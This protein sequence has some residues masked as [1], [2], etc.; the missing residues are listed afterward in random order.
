MSVAIDADAPA[1]EK[2][3]FDAEFDTT[4]DADDELVCPTCVYTCFD[5]YT[6]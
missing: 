2:T 6:Q 3:E 5:S 4:E 1:R